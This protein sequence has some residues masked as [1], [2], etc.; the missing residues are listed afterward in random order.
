[1]NK[2]LKII[3]L[4]VILCILSSC[5][6]TTIDK[7]DPSY[8]L[9]QSTPE[10]QLMKNAGSIYK[11]ISPEKRKELIEILKQINALKYE[12]IKNNQFAISLKEQNLRN[13][14]NDYLDEKTSEIISPE[15]DEYITDKIQKNYCID[16]ISGELKKILNADDYTAYMNKLQSYKNTGVSSDLYDIEDI[17]S[18]Y[19]GIEKLWISFFIERFADEKVL[20]LYKVKRNKSPTPVYFLPTYRNYGTEDLKADKYWSSISA[21]IPKKYIKNFTHLLLAT[22]GEYN[23]MASVTLNPLEYNNKYWVFHIDPEDSDDDFIGTIIHEFGHYLT[24]NVNEV[25]FTEDYDLTRYAEEGLNAK[26]KSLLNKFYNEFWKD[27]CLDEFPTSEEFYLRNKSD[28]V[29]DYAAT[30]VTEDM[31]E[32]FRVFVL[33]EKPAGNSIQER[34]I[35]FFYYESKYAKIRKKIRKNLNMSTP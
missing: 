5:K 33:E 11:D 22:D 32:S 34:K 24:L 28:F 4:C 20:G 6:K 29:S 35:R 8:T 26:E 31:A 19:E 10:T 27:Y 13:E 2:H 1:M 7:Q 25:D 21:I 15:P 14:F 23:T 9:Q 17:V 18:P 30:D 12:R 16:Y 3:Y